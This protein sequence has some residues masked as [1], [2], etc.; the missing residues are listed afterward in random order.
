MMV[1]WKTHWAEFPEGVGSTEYFKQVGKTQNGQPISPEQFEIILKSIENGLALKPTDT[2]LD[3]CCGN[4]LITSRI[5]AK[6]SAI[7]GVD[8]SEPL[9]RVANR[10]HCASNAQ[11]FQRSALESLMVAGE[12]L[13]LFDKV[14]MYEALQHFKRQDLGVILRNIL[15]VSSHNVVVLLA[16]IPD[17]SR[18][19]KFYNTPRRRLDYVVRKI[20]GREAIG[21]WWTREYIEQT[22]Q[23]LGLRCDYIQQEHSLYTSHYRFNIRIARLEN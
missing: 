5:A 12:D 14:Y 17:K 4:G 16:S 9:L 10:D 3:L 13:P 21:T 6:S 1:E 11:Y 20:R 15:E 7:V 22:C 8:F 19:W 2:V 23:K 18:L